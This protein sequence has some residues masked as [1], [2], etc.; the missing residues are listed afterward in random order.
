MN[1]TEHYALPQWVA[2]DPIQRTDFNDAFARLDAAIHTNADDIAPLKSGG[3]V[4]RVKYGSYTGDGTSGAEH[5]NVLS[6][7]FTPVL[8][9]VHMSGS[10]GTGA[11]SIAIRG[12]VGFYNTSATRT[13]QIDWNEASVSWH[14]DFSEDTLHTPAY[15][16]FNSSGVTY[17]YLLLGYSGS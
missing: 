3:L 10:D 1:Q 11:A 5:P 15:S 14:Y 6:C 7:D 17:R 2:D 8:L 16:Q 9:I 12:A 4:C 13:N